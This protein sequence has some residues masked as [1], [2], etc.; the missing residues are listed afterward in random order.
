MYWVP[1]VCLPLCCKRIHWWR[2]GCW[3]HRSGYHGLVWV[4]DLNQVINQK[5]A[6]LQLQINAAMLGLRV[7]DRRSWASQDLGK[8][9]LSLVEIWKTKKSSLRGCSLQGWENVCPG[10][11]TRKTAPCSKVQK[12]AN[13]ARVKRLSKLCRDC[14]GLQ[15][16]LG[17]LVIVIGHREVTNCCSWESIRSV[18]VS[19]LWLPGGGRFGGEK[20]QQLSCRATS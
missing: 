16:K 8:W 2:S 6:S 13:T 7:Y 4:T 1:T 20:H 10:L 14:D 5:M 9:W 12:Q 19:S 17:V 15:K 18:W 3:G 11:M